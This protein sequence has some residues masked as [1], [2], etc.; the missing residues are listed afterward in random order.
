MSCSLHVTIG[1]ITYIRASRYRIG[2]SKYSYILLPMPIKCKQTYILHAWH[3]VLPEPH[4]FHYTEIWV[5]NVPFTTRRIQVFCWS[6]RYKGIKKYITTRHEDSWYY[7]MHHLDTLT[8]LHV[9]FCRLYK[10]KHRNAPHFQWQ[11][12]TCHDEMHCVIS[13]DSELRCFLVG[14]S[15]MLNF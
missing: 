4:A 10:S 12:N 13:D 1:V 2:R 5:K 9:G 7:S 8:I 11:L 3:G 14:L 15:S 6:D